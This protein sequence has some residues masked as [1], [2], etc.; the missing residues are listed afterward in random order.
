MKTRLKAKICDRTNSGFT[1]IWACKEVNDEA[2]KKSETV[3]M[4]VHNKQTISFNM[5]MIKGKD[6][7]PEIIVRELVDRF[8]VQLPNEQTSNH[9][10]RSSF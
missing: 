1:G 3:I 5:S 10:L 7:K 9:S 2:F 8:G 4:D 6:T